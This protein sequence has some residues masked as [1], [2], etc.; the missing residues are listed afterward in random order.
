[1]FSLPTAVVTLYTLYTPDTFSFRSLTFASDDDYV[2]IGRS[3]K[4]ETKNL[5][6]AQHNA[7]FD[8]RVM[9]R[10]HAR[11]GVNMAEKVHISYL[12]P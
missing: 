10:D 1:M 4:R 11:I 9:S 8:S 12:L 5:I 7:W 2:D 6:P 3:S